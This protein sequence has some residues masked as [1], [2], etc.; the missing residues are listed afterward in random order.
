LPEVQPF[1]R[2]RLL[3]IFNV[4]GMFPVLSSY[5]IIVKALCEGGCTMADGGDLGCRVE[6]WGGRVSG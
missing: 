3:R 4:A 6:K 5:R 2:V 1:T